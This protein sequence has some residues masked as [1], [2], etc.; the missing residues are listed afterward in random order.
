MDTLSRR[1]SLLGVAAVALV[2]AACSS[3]AGAGNNPSPSAAPPASAGASG[4]ASGGAYTVEV[5]QDPS[6]GA[7]IAGEDGKTLYLLTKDAMNKSNCSGS[8]AASWPPFVLE[9]GETVAAGAGV[10]GTLG[11]FKR[12]DG[13]EQVAINGVPLYYFAGDHGPGQ[14]NGQGV[15]GVWFLVSPSGAALGAPAASP[16]ASPDRTPGGGK[17]GY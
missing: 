17:Y 12:D 15:N 3:Q 6:M 16:A 2:V 13:S 9:D 14:T 11:T 1:G 7:F 5:H 10:T 8:C 4:S